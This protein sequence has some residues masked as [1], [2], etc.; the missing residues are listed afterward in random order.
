M[1]NFKLRGDDRLL[2]SRPSEGLRACLDDLRMVER[3]P[4]YV[5]DMEIWH[6]T[7]E[8]VEGTPY[9]HCSVCLGGSRLAR[10]YDDPEFFHSWND[11]GHEF[12]PKQE[13]RISSMDDFRKGDIYRGIWHYLGHCEEEIN[14]MERDFRA[15]GLPPSISVPSYHSNRA[16]FYQTMDRIVEIL[17]KAG[18]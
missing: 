15:K 11:L 17:S 2:S 1:K 10:I 7:L 16:G 14:V 3:H 5:V 6:E 8:D 13:A 18:Y 4:D 12:E 9:D